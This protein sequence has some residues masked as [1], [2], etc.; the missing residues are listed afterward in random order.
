MCESLVCCPAVGIIG[1]CANL[2]LAILLT[3]R[4]NSLIQKFTHDSKFT[5]LI[6]KVAVLRNIQVYGLSLYW[7]IMMHSYNKRNSVN[8]SSGIKLSLYINRSIGGISCKWFRNE[9]HGRAS[10]RFPMIR[11][12]KSCILSYFIIR[13]HTIVGF[14]H[15]VTFE[16]SI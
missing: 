10:K 5:T 2:I 12:T 9:G 14:V 11:P 3:L 1:F 15:V 4:Y 6:R 7:K 16:A 8:P 13:C